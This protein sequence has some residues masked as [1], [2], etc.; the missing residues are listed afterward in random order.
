MHLILGYLWITCECLDFRKSILTCTNFY[1]CCPRFSTSVCVCFH[2]CNT[3][4]VIKASLACWT[5]TLSDV[6]VDARYI[7]SVSCQRLVAE[8]P[9]SKPLDFRSNNPIF[10]SWRSSLKS[11]GTARE[12]LLGNLSVFYRED[13]NEN[14]PCCW[15]NYQIGNLVKVKWSRWTRWEL[16]LIWKI[17]HRKSVVFLLFN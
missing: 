16:K 13:A 14:G 17:F 12:N 6:A 11:V 1:G 15:V 10:S 5:P 7:W 8:T 2:W 4:T 9:R 3:M